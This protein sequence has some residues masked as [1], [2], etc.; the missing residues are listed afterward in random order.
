MPI[1]P[2]AVRS[3][4]EAVAILFTQSYELA[5]CRAAGHPSSIT[6]L[7][8]E[9]DETLLDAALLRRQVGIHQRNRA[10][11]PAEKRPDYLPADRFE[12]LQIQKLRGWSQRETARQF[13]LHPTTICAWNRAW[14]CRENIG[15]F[16]GNAPWNKMADGVRWLT[17]QIRSLCPESEFGT[18]RI[19]LELIRSGIEISRSTVQRVLREKK[20]RCPPE[21]VFAPTLA[22]TDT[23]AILKPRKINQTWH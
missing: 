23:S 19:A 1:P 14:R 13:V 12:I 8:A 7:M 21:P 20:P 15:L 6:R 22:N 16:F 2:F 17:H 9:R 18:R 4:I 10:A 11:Y 3:A 5:R